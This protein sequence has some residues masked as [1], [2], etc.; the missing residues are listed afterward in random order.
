MQDNAI[1]LDAAPLGKI[2]PN[3]WTVEWEESV[4]ST[5]KQYNLK[6]GYDHPYFVPPGMRLKDIQDVI[7]FTR[8]WRQAKNVRSRWPCW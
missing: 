3:D 2:V 8:G 6:Y 1:L 7:H 5:D 4:Q